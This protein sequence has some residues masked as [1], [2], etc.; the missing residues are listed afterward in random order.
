M[1]KILTHS[2]T[3][4]LSA[5]LCVV[6]LSDLRAS[7]ATWS[8]TASSGDWAYG[9]NWVGAISA[10]N[11]GTTDN[12]DTA[13]FSTG[14]ST[15]TIVPDAS[16][17][18]KSLIFSS[19]SV[20]AYTIGTTTGNA[21]RLSDGGSIQLTST[22]NNTETLNAPLLLQGNY[23]ATNNASNSARLLN[24]GGAIGG[25]AA[26][27]VTNTL[28]IAGT[29]TGANTLSGIISDGA[30]G[31]KLALTKSGAGVWVLSGTNTFSGGTTLEQ[32]TLYLNNNSAVGTGLFT[33]K[34]GKLINSSGNSRTLTTANSQI[35]DGDFA[36]A[37]KSA[38]ADPKV[39]WNLSLGSGIV[40]LTGNRAIDASGYSCLNGYSWEAATL[41]A[42][43]SITDGGSGFG[44]TKNGAGSLR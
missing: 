5:L 40:L 10:G 1:I 6:S 15:L 14:S 24:L 18:I 39:S 22:V 8:S 23:A 38:Q 33:I 35:W 3:A 26:T 13:T 31:G 30:D 43:G 32:G 19:S 7:D 11:T 36:F 41:T 28:V 12:P 34:G 2:C 20:G 44:L 27:G 29:N 16:R 37:G 17:N 42:A 9:S 21:I 25:T 4:I